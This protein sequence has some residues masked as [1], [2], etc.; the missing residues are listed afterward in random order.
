[1]AQ[2]DWETQPLAKLSADDRDAAYGNALDAGENMKP[3]PLNAEQDRVILKGYREGLANRATDHAIYEQV[4]GG[5]IETHEHQKLADLTRYAAAM[6]RALEAAATMT[7]KEIIERASAEK[8]AATGKWHD[9]NAKESGLFEGHGASH[10]EYERWEAQ[11]TAAKAWGR[12]S[13]HAAAS[14]REAETRPKE[15]AAQATQNAAR[16]QEIGAQAKREAASQE[17][18]ASLRSVT[19]RKAIDELDRYTPHALQQLQRQADT[20]GHRDEIHRLESGAVRR[21]ASILKRLDNIPLTVSITADQTPLDRVRAIREAV[22]Q[23]IEIMPK[24][25]FYKAAEIAVDRAAARPIV[26]S[27]ENAAGRFLSRTEAVPAA[28]RTAERTR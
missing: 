10:A 28:N 13:H 19:P 2:H 11:D 14:V 24:N 9:I 12:V 5:T 23:R 25:D 16:A 3:M 20:P 17:W 4:E 1:M 22:D 18:A 26:Q 15:V 6:D 7:P 8:H 27:I 21:D